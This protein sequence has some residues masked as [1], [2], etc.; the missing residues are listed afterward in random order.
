[1]KRHLTQKIN[2]PQQNQPFRR[3]SSLGGDVSFR[4]IGQENDN[5]FI[6]MAKVTKVYYNKGRL[7]F[8]L[9]N[10][11]NIVQEV[12]GSRG[13]GS[14]P[15][16][17]DFF[18]RKPD[19]TVFGHY[20]PVKIGDS[21]AIA[22]L[23]GKKSNPIV[24]GVYPN[25]S[26]DYEYISPA[27]Y[28]DGDD[29]NSGVAET[30]L[31]D[32]KVYPSMQTEYRS[33]SGTI[34]KALNGHSFLVIDDETSVDYRQL[35]QNYKTVGFFNSNGKTINPLKEK[36]GDWTLIHEDNPKAPNADNHRTRF[37]VSKQ[38]EL[39]V[40]FMDNT[41]T[42][43][44][45]VLEGAQH[46]GFTMTQ[47]YDTPKRKAGDLSDN[48]Y[49]P[50]LYASPRYVR[51]NLG[52]KGKEASLE[53]SSLKDSILQSTQLAVRTDGIYINGKLLVSGDREFSDESLLEKAIENSPFL[54][55]IVQTF[56][57][58]V[59]KASRE[60]SDAYQKAQEATEAA[61]YYFGDIGEGQT[62]SNGVAYIG[63]EKLFSETINT[64]IP[65]QVFLTA[66]DPGNI[67]VAQRE[68]DRF[69]VKSSQPNTKFGW[70]IKSKRKGYEHAR[71]QNVDNTEMDA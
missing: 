2:I 23:N 4:D 29:N 15:I 59:E 71:L 18:G 63:I 44:V 56:N 8:K 41:S 53:S 25:S 51:F 54:K 47:Y 9:A 17:V 65:Y 28:K 6:T 26:Q 37:F 42:G 38:G 24:I 48:V 33:G 58:S 14:A 35:W 10:T 52:G 67:W 21:V 27:M 40:V 7:D 19:G 49:N 62:D 39:Q 66:Y 57:A 12:A 45:L 70:E 31:A 34:A 50:D 16:P 11:N 64:N 46:K 68:H 61:E 43:D 30:G 55:N 36:A 60:T 69:T 22:Y 3:Q 32:R 20:R 5:S 13:V 1:M